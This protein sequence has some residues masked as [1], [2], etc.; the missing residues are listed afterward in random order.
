MSQPISKTLSRFLA[1]GLIGF[2]VDLVG[3]Q[4]MLYFGL[5]AVT[6]RV[7][8]FPIAVVVTWLLHRRYTFSHR[9]SN[10]RT[11]ELTRYLS[12]QLLSNL[13]GFAAYTWLVLHLTT[14]AENP[15]MALIVSSAIGAATN[16]LVSHFVVFNGS[17]QSNDSD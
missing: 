7:V 1:V 17:G 12:G 8:S 13:L 11:R 9:R 14:F 10:K 5:D 6:A 15:V 4:S 3:L 16:Y 2:I